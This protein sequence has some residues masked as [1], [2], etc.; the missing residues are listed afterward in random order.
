VKWAINGALNGDTEFLDK[1]LEQLHMIEFSL[2]YR[3]R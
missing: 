1:K 3:F 2:K